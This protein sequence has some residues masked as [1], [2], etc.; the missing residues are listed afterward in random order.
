MQWKYALRDYSHTIP[1]FLTADIDSALAE[2]DA[3]EFDNCVQMPNQEKLKLEL[4]NCRVGTSSIFQT[5][6]FY[7]LNIN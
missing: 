7:K 4:N 3:I 5:L 2:I 1:V 6:T